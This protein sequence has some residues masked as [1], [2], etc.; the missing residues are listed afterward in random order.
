M[1]IESV[2]CSLCNLEFKSIDQMKGRWRLEHH[3]EIEHL[4]DCSKCERKFTSYSNAAVHAYLTHDIRCVNCGELCEGLCLK[5]IIRNLER[6]QNNI[7]KKDMMNKIERRISEEEAK[8]SKWF[9]GISERQ[10]WK[11]KEAIHALDE[12]MSGCLANSY[13]M[14]GYLPFLE[15]SPKHGKLSKFGRKLVERHQYLSATVK[16]NLYLI[17]IQQMYQGNP[18]TILRRFEEDCENMNNENEIMELT[19]EE[20]VGT[21]LCLSERLIDGPSNDEW[22]NSMFIKTFGVPDELSTVNEHYPIHKSLSNRQEE[23]VKEIPA[24]SDDNANIDDTLVFT[25][26][27]PET[28]KTVI[29]NDNSDD[30][31]EHLEIKENL[32][33][34]HM[35]VLE[36]PTVNKIA[37]KANIE[38]SKLLIEENDH[39]EELEMIKVSS[40]SINQGDE[41]NYEFLLKEDNI[42]KW[43]SETKS[44][45]FT[46]IEDEQ[47]IEL[48]RKDTNMDEVYLNDNTTNMFDLFTTP[49]EEELDKRIVETNNP[50]N[51]EEYNSVFNFETATGKNNLGDRMTRA[52]EDS[53]EDKSDRSVRKARDTEYI[54]L[55][56]KKDKFVAVN[57][58]EIEE[59]EGVSS[60]LRVLLNYLVNWDQTTEIMEYDSNIKGII[61]AER[62]TTVEIIK[63]EESK[64]EDKIKNS[65][66][67]AVSD[68]QE[69]HPYISASNFGLLKMIDDPRPRLEKEGSEIIIYGS[70]WI[71]EDP[72]YFLGELKETSEPIVIRN[73]NNIVIAKCMEVH[74][75]K[76]Y[77]YHAK[78]CSLKIEQPI[79]AIIDSNLLEELELIMIGQD[80][81]KARKIDDISIVDKNEE[82]IVD[83]L[84]L[85]FG[86]EVYPE[87]D[88]AKEMLTGNG[89][90]VEIKLHAEVLQPGEDFSTINNNDEVQITNRTLLAEIKLIIEKNVEEEIAITQGFLNNVQRRF[91]FDSCENT[92]LII[93]TRNP[94]RN[95]KFRIVWSSKKCVETEAEVN[96]IYYL[97][98]INYEDANKSQNDQNVQKIENL[99]E[100]PMP[101][102]IVR[103]SLREIF[104]G[105]KMYEDVLEDGTDL[106]VVSFLLSIEAPGTG[107]LA[108]NCT[109]PRTNM[110]AIMGKLALFLSI[111][112][113][114]DIEII[115]CFLNG[116]RRNMI[117]ETEEIRSTLFITDKPWRSRIFAIEDK[118]D[119]DYF[120]EDDITHD[121][122]E[123]IGDTD[124]KSEG[125]SSNTKV[126]K[127]RYFI[128]KKDTEKYR[129][130]IPFKDDIINEDEKILDDPRNGGKVEVKVKQ[131]NVLEKVSVYDR[132]YRGI[133]G[134]SKVAISGFSLLKK[135]ISRTSEDVKEMIRDKESQDIDIKVEEKVKILD[136]NV[137]A[138]NNSNQYHKKNGLK[139]RNKMKFEPISLPGLILI[140]IL[141]GSVGAGI[142]NKNNINE[143]EKD[144]STW[145]DSKESTKSYEDLV[146]KAYDCLQENQPGTT[147][148]LRAPKKCQLQDGSAYYPSKLTNAQVL[149]QLSLVPINVSLCTVHFYVSVGWCG[150][151]YALENFKHADIQTLRSQILVNERDCHK[152]KTDG[153]LKISTPEYGSIGELEIMLNLR[154]GRAQALFQPVGVSRPNS[155][156][157]GGVFYPPRNDDR[158]IMFLD[159]K[160]H[161][162]RK[163]LWQTDRIRRAVVTYELEADVKKIEAFISVSENKMIIP[164]KLEIERKRNFRKERF[165]DMAA[166]KNTK[167]ENEET[168]L[169]T[170]QDLAYGTIT[171]NI[172]NLPRNEC[173]AIRSVSKVRQGKIMKSKLENLS[174]IKYNHDG[175]ETAVTLEKKIN[176]C[177]R[178]MYE[179]RVKNIV[180]VLLGRE[181]GFLENEKLKI[182]EVDKEIVHA[183]RVRSAL[184]SVELSQDTIYQDINYRMCIIQR[185]QVLLMQSMLSNQ[186][187][188]LT[189]GN[190]DTVYSHT[191]GEISKVRQCKKIGVKIRNGDDKCC[192]ELPV[193]IG[194]NYEI[195]AYMRPINRQI[196]KVCTPRVCSKHTSPVFQIGTEDAEIWIKVEESEIIATKT[197]KDLKVNSHNKEETMLLHE[198]DMFD[199]DLKEKFSLFTFVHN[200]RKL[201]EGTVI[202]KMYPAQVLTKLNNIEDTKVA[203]EEENFISYRIQDAILP[204]PLNY[205]HILPDWLIITV[206]GIV[207]LI[208]LKVVM[209]PLLACMTLISDS[210]LS[211]IQRLASV[212]VPATT[213]SWIHSKK[214]PQIEMKEIEDVEARI[215]DLE[216]EIKLV[217][218][219]MIKNG[220]VSTTKKAMIDE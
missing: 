47:D 62:K 160:S 63:D 36:L 179:T 57:G 32:N 145:K 64:D 34:N 6:T 210:S 198:S 159:Y 157:Q 155:W 135:T 131:E 28:P 33:D 215:A 113:H 82:Q 52:N 80:A 112:E 81:R 86:I 149:E 91:I 216:V 14:L 101:G 67:N 38:T 187:E 137:E 50:L 70:A 166:Y 96:G 102:I 106:T 220:K 118:T 143:I 16:L 195:E 99:I 193:Y 90:K 94:E 45:S 39:E 148:S 176:L 150:G 75:T 53:A 202:Q 24:R 66:K 46:E 58:K 199:E 206:I 209:D 156:C 17:D 161:F 74:K 61:S 92:S 134:L 139:L 93:N 122:N 48:V 97:E 144:E 88:K 204:W 111:S 170:Y 72:H 42:V 109:N 31:P 18:S 49:E 13:G 84:E 35:K 192:Q 110:K 3:Q 116:V 119:K 152:A 121:N 79:S 133:E 12:G 196:T 174:I 27:K 15:A 211:I 169:E 98:D 173:E 151:E 178:E 60:D 71:G 9:E 182:D 205:M 190:G 191:A 203:E 77:N 147:L 117:I 83:G 185:Q 41:F 8:Y 127:E 89:K 87:I 10:M 4:A 23:M 180:V 138:E 95:R 189:D 184:N 128:Y 5:N 158:S 171:F 218:S 65:D 2:I 25:E 126:K 125:T 162:E 104:K 181:E 73:R 183:A 163:Q 44:E 120:E 56:V 167:I 197:P 54:K 140:A 214:K 165:V 124:G 186:M 154:G 30:H 22:T 59:H 164:N 212:I 172:S 51:L 132:I 129:V 142:V 68:C 188:L 217:R 100:E 103:I 76:L 85:I 200:A 177:G 123:N 130:A 40:Y 213:V 201:L 114:D 208:L 11:L 115:R 175:E 146:I 7:E 153:F 26:E 43:F 207:A 136:R 29:S 194:E 21:H 37:E 78:E 108:E 20:L 69:G 105:L 107:S 55:T 168:F 219:A 19:P 141:F 1:M